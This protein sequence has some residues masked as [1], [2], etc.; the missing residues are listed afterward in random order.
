M[1]TALLFITDIWFTSY[2]AVHA[3]I[4]V[5]AIAACTA[6]ILL[7]LLLVAFGW[8][9][10]VD[11]MRSILSSPVIAKDGASETAGLSFHSTTLVL[12][13]PLVEL[14]ALVCF[15]LVLTP[16]WLISW[17]FEG[18]G[19]LPWWCSLLVDFVYLATAIVLFNWWNERLVKAE[20]LAADASD[21][22]VLADFNAAQQLEDM[23]KMRTPMA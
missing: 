5:V 18:L 13:L 22:N 19:G 3:E 6:V 21:A 7:V 20:L 9:A 10:A 4:Y 12:C 14:L 11:A 23:R 16:F 15:A 1:L 8:P 2:T 17:I